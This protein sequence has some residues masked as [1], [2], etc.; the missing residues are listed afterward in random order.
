MSKIASL[1]TSGASR[2]PG[3][4]G[5]V[6]SVAAAV[7]LLAAF[8]T[9]SASA[10]SVEACNSYETAREIQACKA[11]CTCWGYD[12]WANFAARNHCSEGYEVCTAYKTRDSNWRF[13]VVCADTPDPGQNPPGLSNLASIVSFSEETPSACVDPITADGEVTEA[14]TVEGTA[15]VSLDEE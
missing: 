13:D 11:I 10:C 9:P 2:R 7:V 4:A 12:L 1:L 14:V 8:G 6:I 5:F 15:E 3:S